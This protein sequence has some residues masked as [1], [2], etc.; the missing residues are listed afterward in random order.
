M[1]GRSAT[2]PRAAGNRTHAGVDGELPRGNIT[3]QGTFSRGLGNQPG[4]ERFDA[5]M[6][7]LDVRGAATHLPSGRGARREPLCERCEHGL[8]PVE[9]SPSVRGPTAHW[10]S[11]RLVLDGFAGMN[12]VKPI[13]AA[14]AKRQPATT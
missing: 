10:G 6:P 2:E 12:V 9:H 4:Q 13:T 14:A 8:Q 5:C 1:N 11:G 7:R 3:A